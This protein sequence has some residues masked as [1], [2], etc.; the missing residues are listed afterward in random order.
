MEVTR[1]DFNSALLCE[2]KTWKYSKLF[3]RYH[4]LFIEIS[5]TGSLSE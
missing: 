4:S 2:T 1:K 5:S 3:H